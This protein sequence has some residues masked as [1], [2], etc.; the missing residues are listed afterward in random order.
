MVDLGEREF[1]W[2]NYLNYIKLQLNQL[3][4]APAIPWSA[5]L[6]P[7]RSSMYPKVEEHKLPTSNCPKGLTRLSPPTSYLIFR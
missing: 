3:L 2:V 4:G 5:G 7:V 6:S 1:L